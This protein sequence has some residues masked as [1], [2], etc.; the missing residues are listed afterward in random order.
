MAAPSVM[1]RPGL[2]VDGFF[3]EMLDQH[4]I[5]NGAIL[6]PL[7]AAIGVDDS[8]DCFHQLRAICKTK[9]LNQEIVFDG[10]QLAGLRGSN[11]RRI[12]ILDRRATPDGHFGQK[13]H[14]RCHT[15]F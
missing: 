1:N 6:V 3:A 2:T 15:A 12:I 10:F 5:H 7:A 4:V 13:G 14:I 9:F 11:G 8:V